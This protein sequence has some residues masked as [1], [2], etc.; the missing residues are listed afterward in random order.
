MEYD[1][2]KRTAE[3]LLN[4]FRASDVPSPESV[5]APRDVTTLLIEINDRIFDMALTVT[6]AQQAAGI[7]SSAIY[8]RFKHY[9]GMTPKH[10]IDTMR[11]KATRVLLEDS[12]ISVTTISFSLGY[13]YLK[14]FEDVFKRHVGCTPTE[15]RER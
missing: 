5:A 6:G 11:I 13:S 8:G 7:S 12:H 9:V 10:Y 1:K 2:Q 4:S 15:Y 3:R 14:T